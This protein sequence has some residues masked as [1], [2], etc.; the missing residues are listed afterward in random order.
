MDERFKRPRTGPLQPSAAQEEGFVV[1]LDPNAKDGEFA[2]V[3]D[4]PEALEGR[5]PQARQAGAEAVAGIPPQLHRA[6]NEV[7]GFLCGL[8]EQLDK[9]GRKSR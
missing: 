7:L 2:F 8:D 6:V 5:V 1:R 4:Q 3:I 9:Q